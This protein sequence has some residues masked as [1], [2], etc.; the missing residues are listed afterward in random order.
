MSAKNIHAYIHG[1]YQSEKN[2]RT[3]SIQT[4]LISRSHTAPK[5]WKIHLPAVLNN[6]DVY[7]V[8]CVSTMEETK[9]SMMI[10]CI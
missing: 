10:F 9:C 5:H 1:P 6:E 7:V 8:F 4:I 2:V 3:K